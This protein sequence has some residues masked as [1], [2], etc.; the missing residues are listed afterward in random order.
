MRNLKLI[1]LKKM[2]VKD[3]KVSLPKD[4]KKLEL[5]RIGLS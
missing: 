5:V 2:L 3:K 1:N 4:S